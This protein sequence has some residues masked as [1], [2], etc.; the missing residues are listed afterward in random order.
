MHKVNWKIGQY[1]FNKVNAL[2][3]EKYNFFQDVNL[4]L[5]L[6]FTTF[7]TTKHLKETT[8]ANPIY[9]VIGGPLSTK[10]HSQ[11]ALHHPLLT[12]KE[13]HS[14]PNWFLK[15]KQLIKHN[16]T[17]FRYNHN[18]LLASKKKGIIFTKKCEI[19]I[20]PLLFFLLETVKNHLYPA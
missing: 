15:P 19:S 10:L 4:S 6:P 11:T 12:L 17:H 7:Q 9:L 5:N 3:F 1:T 13:A 14:F 8:K 2:P 18:S 16:T 20:L